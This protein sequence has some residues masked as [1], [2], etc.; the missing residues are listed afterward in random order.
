MKEKLQEYRSS[1][2]G[3]KIDEPKFLSV[4]CRFFTA[5]HELP[6]QL[7]I[8]RFNSKLVRPFREA[9]FKFTGIH[10]ENQIIEKVG[11]PISNILR[12][13]AF[14]TK[15]NI[16]RFISTKDFKTRLKTF[17][18]EHEA[19]IQ[20]QDKIDEPFYFEKRTIELY[21]QTQYNTVENVGDEN[22]S[23][24]KPANHADKPDILEEEPI[25]MDEMAIKEEELEKWITICA[26]YLLETIHYDEKIIIRKILNNPQIT[27]T[28]IV[29]IQTF[30]GIKK[31]STETYRQITNLLILL[32]QS[33]LSNPKNLCRYIIQYKQPKACKFLLELVRG[34][35]IDLIE[36]STLSEN[37]RHA[38]IMFVLDIF[39]TETKQQMERWWQSY[40]KH[41]EAYQPQF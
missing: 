38:I 7:I 12:E 32:C 26:K 27:N 40:T 18:T 10:P 31:L 6:T 34:A 13:I 1:R 37:N 36:F 24:T 9:V 30:C 33:E 14:I 2:L 5:E 19:N 35:G 17:C 16:A 21:L 25:P 22:G 20:D 41:T 29:E 28:L 11:Q 4:L 23:K 15:M 8:G 39:Q 3:V